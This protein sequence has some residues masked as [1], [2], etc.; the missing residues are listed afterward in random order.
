MWDGNA[1]RGSGVFYKALQEVPWVKVRSFPFCK[2]KPIVSPVTMCKLH[3]NV[4]DEDVSVC[5]L[6]GFVHGCSAAVSRTRA[7]VFGPDD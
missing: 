6:T 1:E 2:R 5:V 3:G 4:S 7:G